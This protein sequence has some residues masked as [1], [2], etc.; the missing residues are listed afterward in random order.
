MLNKKAAP[1]GAAFF[2]QTTVLSLLTSC[3]QTVSFTAYIG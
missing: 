3:K 1:K 2:I